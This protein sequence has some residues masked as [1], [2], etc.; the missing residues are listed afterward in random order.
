MY[1]T[2]TFGSIVMW[3]NMKCVRVFEY[4]H[5]YKYFDEWSSKMRKH[6]QVIKYS[7]KGYFTGSFLFI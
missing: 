3:I 4:K 2:K 5:D 7:Y 1:S 6:W